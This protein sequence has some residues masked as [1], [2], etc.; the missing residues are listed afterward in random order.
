MST[1]KRKAFWIIG[2][3]AAILVVLVVLRVWSNVRN[4]RRHVQVDNLVVS[5]GQAKVQ[6]MPVTLTAV[7]QVVSAHSVLIHPQV[8]GM[9][10]QVYFTEG[11]NVAAGQKLFLIDP[12]PF[13]AALASAK[14]AWENAKANADRLEPLAKQDFATPQEYENARATADQAQAAYQQ[15]QINLSYTEIRAPIAGRTGS[16]S[17]KSGNIVAPTDATPLVA[18]NQ[19]QPIQVQFQLAQQFLPQV[20]GYDAKHTLKVTITRED[21]T[22]NLDDG[23]LVFIDNT[24]NAATGTVM[25]KASLPNRQEQLWPGQYVGVTLQLALQQDAVVIPQ[26]AVLT[27]QSGNYV[28][29]VKNGVAEQQPI[30]VDRTVGD[31]AVVASGLEGGDLLVTAV[32]RNLRP[33]IHVS[34]APV[35]SEPKPE[36]DVP[37][38][39]P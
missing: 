22:G 1:A 32:P 16:L 7:G 14:A 20:R 21:G 17:V 6:P 4:S 25:F 11:Q 19:M 39:R 30:K 35:G 18:V 13:Q 23:K 2:G 8:S 27:G 26:S 36:I 10:K 38:S 12:A 9:L 24:V 15:A 34:A 31:V 33:G 37:G 28:Y 5:M 3:I 29:L